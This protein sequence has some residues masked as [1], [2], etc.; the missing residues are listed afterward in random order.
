MA[1]PLAQDLE[2]AAREQELDSFDARVRQRALA[3]L[4]GMARAGRLALPPPG[5]AVNLHYHTFFSYNA[6][7]YSPSRIAWLARRRGLA[8]A[9]I[10]DFDVLDGLEEFLSG[11]AQLGLKVCGGLETR[12]FV[13]EF[14]HYVINSPGE[15]GISYHMGVAFPSAALPPHLD[16][17]LARLRAISAER[18]RELVER[19]NAYLS[20]VALDYEQDVLPLT[21][22]GNATERHICLAYARKARL[23]FPDDSRL[24]GFWSEKLGVG[25]EELDLPEGARLQE[26]IRA[27]TMKQGGAGY[28]AP[29]TGSFPRLEEAN[30]FLL[31]AGAIPTHTWLDGSSKGEQRI[32]ELLAVEIASGVAAINVIP[33]RNY[34]PGVPEEKVR[35]LREVVGLAERLDLIVVVG[36]EMNRPGQKF[37]D[38]LDSPELRELA[39]AFRKGAYIVYAHSALQ[40]AAGLG[41]TSEWAARRLGGRADRNRFFEQVGRRLQPEAA[42]AL[43]GLGRD[44]APEE[45]LARAGDYAAPRQ[46]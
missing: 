38:D 46:P 11:G 35:N 13:P 9:G 15:P 17:F 27:R 34:G 24:A 37:A 16:G 44:P 12:V 4:H 5:E 10:V 39:P 1:E 43:A 25:P 28:V 2:I 30:R 42:G 40:R 45:V 29:D 20:P 23:T 33:D 3:A 18:N 19:V 36:T 22:S 7:G 31:E 21:P 26:L 8:V 14:A 6:Y 32:E 41:Y